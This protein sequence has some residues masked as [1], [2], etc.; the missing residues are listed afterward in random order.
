MVGATFTFDGTNSYVQIP[1][2]AVLRPTNLTVE[3]W[4][5]FDGLDSAGNSS[6]GQQYIV[7][8]QNSRSTAFEGF[9]LTKTRSTNGDN[10]VFQVSSAA[11][12]TISARSA[13]MVST[14]LWYDVAGV[15]GS[16]FIQLF[17]NGQ[18]QAQA[19]VGF[20]QDYGNFPVLLGTTGQPYWDHKLKGALDE[21]SLYDHA[22]SSNEVAAIYAAGAGGKCK[23]AVAPSIVTQPQSQIVMAGTNAAFTV[24]ATNTIPLSYHWQFNDA[25]INGA[26]NTALTLSNAQPSTAGN[27]T[28]VVTNAGGAVTSV[29]AVLSV[30]AP[31]AITS[32]PQNSTNAP[33]TTTTFSANVTGTAPLYCQWWQT[34][35]ALTNSGRVNGATSSL[36]TLSNVQPGDGGN[37]IL[38]VSN[39]FG[40]VTST[41]VTLTVTG[42]PVITSQPADQSVSSDT[43]VSFSVVASGTLPLGCRWQRNGTN[44]V[45]IDNISGANGPM[46]T[47][48]NVQTNDAGNYRVVITNSEGSITSSVGSLT[49]IQAAYV[50]ADAVVLVNSSSPKY[51]DF[52]HYLQ[53]Y[54]DNFGVPYTI[55]DIATNAVGT[56]V[57]RYALIIVGHG[58]LDANNLHLDGIAQD[59]ISMA[60]SN[61]TG[62]VNFD[63][64]LAA[65]GSP[66]YQFVQNIFGFGYGAPS[67]GTNVAFPPTEPLSQMHYIT[68][69][70]QTNETLVL[71]NVMTLANLTLSPNATAVALSSGK[72]FVA[73]TKFG[74]GRAV[75][76]ASYD[77]MSTS[78]QGPLNGLDDL[79]WRSFVWAARKPFVMRGMPNFVTMRVDDVSGPFSWVHTANQAGFKPYLALFISNITTTAANDLRGLTTN[80]NATASVHSFTDSGFCYYNHSGHA[81]WP[82][83]VI[84]NNFVQGGQWHTNHGIPISKM[85][86]AHWS[87]MGLNAFAG[88]KSWGIEFVLIEIPPGAEEYIIPPTPWL[89]A[90]PYRLYENPAAGDSLLPLFYADFLTVPGHPEFDGQFFDPYTEIRN[91]A[92]STVLEGGDWAPDTNIAA[93]VDRGTKQIKRGLDSMTLGNVF[94]HEGHIAP[95]PNATWLAILQ[96]IT[97]NLAAYKPIYVTMDYANQYIRARRTSRIMASDYDTVSGRVTAKVSGKTDMDMVVQIFVG[98][99]SSISNSLG[100]LPG[101]SGAMTNTLAVLEVPPTIAAEPQSL[102]VVAG[103]NAV[104]T[105][106]VAGAAPLIYH[107]Q[108]NGMN[109]AGATSSGYALSAAQPADAGAYS[110]V[111][112]NVL[113]AAI[114]TPA[115]LTVI[116]HPALLGTVESNLFMISFASIPGQ[117]YVIEYINALGS[118]CWSILTSVIAT[119]TNV[120]CYDS[121]TGWPQRFYRVMLASE[122]PEQIK[123]RGTVQG[124]QFVLAFNATT[125]KSY[126]VEYQDLP[127]PWSAWTNIMA[128]TTNVS[129]TNPLTSTQRFYRVSR[130]LD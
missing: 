45:D 62:L 57:G 115:M 6:A 38:V 84:S 58:Q 130:P 59:N 123:L 37:F 103:S 36:L 21:V 54:L 7:F 47:L 41:V 75:Q 124:N 114:S 28:V 66:N 27:Y 106:V 26:T 71:S 49:V 81:A 127:G 8:R 121:M 94:T 35:V 1:D 20:P 60:V 65:G 77:W 50:G 64:A 91:V 51:V 42:P 4:V 79:V 122:L 102:K 112:S 128:L 108:F 53:P 13:A 17:V 74:Q 52:Q 97:N 129:L 99:D 33:G 100:S 107:W 83:N 5:R 16:N 19:A 63:G 22:L 31:P 89:M 18:L 70:H 3:A 109:I 72:P 98:A 95:I 110:V 85:M 30:L 12:V 61:G 69:R 24:T 126:T 56:N 14:G 15:R 101:F 119:G 9:A 73:V 93:T 90:G 80:G 113:G 11:G 120:V 23:T 40:V 82:D 76:W 2:T 44:L 43:E 88:L 32:Q 92:P 48:G 125:G 39:A 10:F 118:D 96:G 67:A 116:P 34:G 55:L 29:V 86:I 117:V 104:F 46:L 78:V 105:V 111:V 87:E 68:A 25:A